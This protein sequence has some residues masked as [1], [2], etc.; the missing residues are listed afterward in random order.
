MTV[1]NRKGAG[2]E[3]SLEQAF[4]EYTETFAISKLF[5]PIQ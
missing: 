3:P 4:H 2:N 5:W 1:A